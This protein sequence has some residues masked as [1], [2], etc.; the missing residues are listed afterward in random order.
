M[1]MVPWMP[2]WRD[3]LLQPPN[4]EAAS[5]P[6]FT[7]RDTGGSANLGQAKIKSR[8]IGNL[9]PDEW[10]CQPSLNGCVGAAK[11]YRVFKGKVYLWP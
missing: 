9:D 8:L 5:C 6:R 2:Y 10:T 7:I 4:M 3:T 1:K 11:F